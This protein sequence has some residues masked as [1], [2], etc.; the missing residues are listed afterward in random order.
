MLGLAA[1]VA[2]ADGFTWIGLGIGNV[3]IIAYA[4]PALIVVGG[5][6]MVRVAMKRALA[7]DDAAEAHA[8]AEA[9]AAQQQQHYAQ[10]QYYAQ[11]QAQ[12]DYWAQ[13]QAAAPQD[14]ART[15]RT[16]LADDPRQRPP[17]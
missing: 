4:L 15:G 11:Q 6:L 1:P 7:G 14:L 16:V 12:Q 17:G 3:P 8:H 9:H 13:Q 10:Q 5:A 2:M